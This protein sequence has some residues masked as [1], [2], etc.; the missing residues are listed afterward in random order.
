MSRIG[1]KRALKFRVLCRRIG[2]CFCF[3]SAPMDWI[4]GMVT[5]SR[6]TY[7]CEWRDI[8][9]IGFFRFDWEFR[10][11]LMVVSFVVWWRCIVLS[12]IAYCLMTWSFSQIARNFQ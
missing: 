1:W 11:W 12:C 8:S 5:V 3:L 6:V 9:K 2:C 7:G 10:T 4:L